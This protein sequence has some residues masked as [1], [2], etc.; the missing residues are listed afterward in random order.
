MKRKIIGLITVISAVLLILSSC[1][2]SASTAPS[3][4][5]S[6]LPSPSPIVSAPSQSTTPKPSPSISP[7][8]TYTVKTDYSKLT[9][10]EPME[11]I[12]TRLSDE[13]M[14]ELVPSDDYGMLLPYTGELL[15]NYYGDPIDERY[16]L[17]TADGIIVTDAMYYSIYN[18]GSFF[19][20]SKQLDNTG[21]E[22]PEY[23]DDLNRSYALCASDGSWVTPFRYSDFSTLDDVLLL[24]CDLGKNI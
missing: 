8:V 7:D 18:Y 23:C 16:G 10:Y 15:Y 22:K 12:Y 13:Y 3:P 6:A 17:V 4:S 24:Y 14:A 9:P 1:S 21:S 20:L 2:N 19:V 11:E 5:V